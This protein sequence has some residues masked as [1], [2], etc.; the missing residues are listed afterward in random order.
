MKVAAVAAAAAVGV[1]AVAFAEP[2]SYVLLLQPPRW[3]KICCTCNACLVAAS[4][5]SIEHTAAAVVLDREK[6][7]PYH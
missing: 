7:K 2:T 5:K 6:E 3:R 1:G 4:V